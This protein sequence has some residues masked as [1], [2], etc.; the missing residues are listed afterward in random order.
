MHTARR[1][2]A[3]R[4]WFQEVLAACPENVRTRASPVPHRVHGATEG[5]REGKEIKSLFYLGPER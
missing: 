1:I 3:L 4:E 2:L 5:N